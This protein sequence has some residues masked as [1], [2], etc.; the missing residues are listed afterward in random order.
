MFLRKDILELI[1][2]K[3]LLFHSKLVLQLRHP[4]IIK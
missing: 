1:A 3:L 2:N 4:N